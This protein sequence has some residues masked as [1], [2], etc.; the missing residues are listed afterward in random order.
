[1]KNLTDKQLQ[2]EAKA[3]DDGMNEGGEGYNPYTDELERREMEE[4]RNKPKTLTD[5]KFEIYHELEI[6]DCA[7]ARE[8]GT[9]NQDEIDKLRKELKEITEKEEEEFKG[10]WT[11]E[12]TQERRQDWNDF[13]KALMVD[14][15]ISGE[16][17]PKIYQ[18]QK[19]QGWKFDDLKK[20]IKSLL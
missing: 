8:C 18:R 12:T 3:W 13:V 9:Y 15:R 20:A 16:D 17:Q 5:R 6:K 7:I 4:Q 10:E 2:A 1:M 11:K 14:G 19:D